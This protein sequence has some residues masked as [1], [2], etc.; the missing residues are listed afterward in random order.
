MASSKMPKRGIMESFGKWHGPK[1]E[2][3]KIFQE[4]EKGIKSSRMRNHKL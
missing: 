3:D 4:I 1:S 2:L